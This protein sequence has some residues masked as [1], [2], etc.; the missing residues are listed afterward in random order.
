[1]ITKSTKTSDHVSYLWVTFHVL[2][3]FGMKLN[4]KTCAFVATGMFIGYIVH[5]RGIEANPKKIKAVL[6]MRSPR[7]TKEIQ[8]LVGKVVTLS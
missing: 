1:M 7:T 2:K 5:Q 8:S 3:K 4:P 6:D